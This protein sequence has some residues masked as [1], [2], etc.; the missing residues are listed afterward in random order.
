M[1]Y[2]ID[3]LF[4]VVLPSGYLPNAVP[5]D[6]A[7]VSYIASLNIKQP[8]SK[9]Y[10]E[11]PSENEFT[12]LFSEKGTWPN[13]LTGFFYSTPCYNRILDVK[14]HSLFFGKQNNKKF[15]YPIRLSPHFDNFVGH[16][17]AGPGV[18]KL[19]GEY[20]WKNI[21]ERA[22]TDI[23]QGRGFILLDY[24]M[25]PFIKKS[26]FENLHFTLQHSEI[27]KSQ[28]ILCTNSFNA[29][30]LY[31]E[32][33]NE[34]E[35]KLKVFN[36]PHCLE[37]SSWF[38]DISINSNRNN[39]L[40]EDYFKQLR[41]MKRSHH[42]LMKIKSPRH[43]RVPLLYAM[44]TNNLL[45][46]G[47][48]SFLSDV[49][50]NEASVNFCKQYFGFE[51]LIDNESVQELF[52][53]TPHYL[54]SENPLY[55]SQVNAWTD[56][57]YRPHMDS[58]FDICFETFF[59]E[60]NKSLTEKIF[61]PIVNFQP[62]L[63]V[64]YPGALEL[65]RNLG[66]KTFDGFIDESYDLEQDHRIR[67]RKIY[68]EIQRLCAMSIDEIHE[69]FWSMEDILVHNHRHLINHHK[70]NLIGEELIKHLYD[71]TR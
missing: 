19:N 23:R 59:N 33:F 1:K 36:L 18:S 2:E 4:D 44:Y 46:Y 58:Y 16:N 10:L 35:Q 14:E 67:F 17:L 47:D 32:W 45:Q 28:I 27:P 38:Y 66:F 57:H 53:E 3:F 62:F 30:Q 8:G 5:L 9:P 20:F 34:D 69:W 39:C 60:E 64:A 42:F 54:K 31:D 13:S 50:Y 29:K 65:L 37:H 15:V 24:S 51:D 48:W 12:S 25:E 63:F 6:Y 22:L 56:T 52:K 55:A 26:Q 11:P 70:N 68:N 71:I 41:N 21:S 49:S 40:S 7:I 43:H 61:K